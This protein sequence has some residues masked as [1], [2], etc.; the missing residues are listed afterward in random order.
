MAREGCLSMLDY[1]QIPAKN[2]QAFL[3]DV[4]YKNMR[5]IVG[6][7]RLL[8]TDLVPI[9]DP[10]VHTNLMK[11]LQGLER[12]IYTRELFVVDN[13]S[14]TTNSVTQSKLTPFYFNT[15]DFL[16]DLKLRIIKDIAHILYVDNSKDGIKKW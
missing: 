3:T 15:L 5:M 16:S 9:L 8:L 13:W 12:A 11:T 7:M 10:T 2:K 1:V 6:E 4:Q 14:V